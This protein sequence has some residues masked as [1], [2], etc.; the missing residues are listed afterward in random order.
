MYA[1]HN[2]HILLSTTA[3]NEHVASYHVGNSLEIQTQKP[4]H[5]IC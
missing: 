4:R 2:S 1:N 5:R 3:T